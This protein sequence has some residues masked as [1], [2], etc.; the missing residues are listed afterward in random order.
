M[1]EERAKKK[2]SQVMTK[3]SYNFVESEQ[4]R[5]KTEDVSSSFIKYSDFM[6]K[7]TKYSQYHISICR[8]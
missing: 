2:D 5:L 4:N 3:S 7:N 6:G 1:T 8:L